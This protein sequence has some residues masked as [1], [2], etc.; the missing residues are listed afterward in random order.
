MGGSEGLEGRD[1]K[2]GGKVGLKGK[3][4]GREKRKERKG[5]GTV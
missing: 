5:K 4:K 3:W 1:R 2:A